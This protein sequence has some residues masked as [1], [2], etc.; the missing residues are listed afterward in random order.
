M[1]KKDCGKSFRQG[2]ACKNLV[3][4]P[5]MAPRKLGKAQKVS[6]NNIPAQKI[7]LFFLMRIRGGS[8]EKKIPCPHPR[9]GAPICL[10][11]RCE[12]VHDGEDSSPVPK[13]KTA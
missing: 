7:E 8:L 3:P 5:P 13:T 6:A 4:V 2:H 12:C 10:W 9:C 1:K 11:D